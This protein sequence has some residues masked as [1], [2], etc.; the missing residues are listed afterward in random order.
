MKMVI[1]TLLKMCLLK[2]KGSNRALS[3]LPLCIISP[4]LVSRLANY[5]LQA[6]EYNI[7]R[8]ELAVCQ[9]CTRPIGP[10]TVDSY[11]VNNQWKEIIY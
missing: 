8:V 7:M 9:T 11:C 1:E 3:K 6:N 2:H 5:Y 10:S 4:T